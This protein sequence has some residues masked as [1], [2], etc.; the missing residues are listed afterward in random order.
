[1]NDEQIKKFIKDNLKIKIQVW[2]MSKRMDAILYFD[3]PSKDFDMDIVSI[4]SI[5][6]IDKLIN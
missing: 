5:E 4:S 1:M 3:D 2:P 6:N